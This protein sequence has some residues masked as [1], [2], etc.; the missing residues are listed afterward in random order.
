MCYLIIA[1]YYN[2]HQPVTRDERETISRLR[3]CVLALTHQ[4]IML[5]DTTIQYTYDS[6]QKYEVFCAFIY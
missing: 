5:F 4:K 2:D 3:N 6:S 1:L